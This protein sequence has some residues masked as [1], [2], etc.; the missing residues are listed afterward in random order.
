EAVLAGEEEV[1]LG[2]GAKDVATIDDDY[3]I[4]DTQHAERL[5]DLRSA[6][7]RGDAVDDLVA[8]ERFEQLD[9]AGERPPFGEDLAEDLAVAPLQRLALVVRQ[10]ATDLARHRPG[11]QPAAHP[12]P[13]MDP[14]AVD[15]K[16]DL[17]QRPLPRMDVRIDRVHERPIEVEDQ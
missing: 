10:A 15:R 2:L 12:D 3:V 5:V 6:A 4:R 14:P 8:P 9:G 11:E 7:R 16:V 13:P 17:E 1:G